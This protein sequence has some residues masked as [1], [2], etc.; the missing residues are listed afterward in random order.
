MEIIKF[1]LDVAIVAIFL[2]VNLSA[3]LYYASGK[4]T[5]REYAVGDKKFSTSTL[6]ATI[7]ATCIG[8]GF[9]SG[10]ITE[11]YKQG[12]Y[13]IIPAM[14]EPLALIIVGYFLIPR[15]SEF[16][17]CLSVADA[18]G[19]L[20]GRYVR[21]M[22]AMAGIFLCIG[23]VALQFKVGASILGIFFGISSFYALLLCAVIVT[24]YSAFGGI[25]AV[26]FTDVIQFFT[27][28][29]VIPVI[30]L[31]IWGTLNDPNVLFETLGRNP[32]FD[33]EQ[34]FDF[35]NSR[36]T[37]TIF[38]LMF[39]L[40][41][42]FQPVFFQRVIMARNTLQAKKAFVIG[43]FICLAILFI[44]SWV[45]I[46]LLSSNSNLDPNNLL[47]HIISTYSY[48][49]LKGLTA[50]GVM[51]VI[52]SSADSYINSA[53]VL[54]TNDILKAFRLNILGSISELLIASAFSFFVGAVGCILAFKSG[55][56]LGLLL[57]TFS[58]YTP[59][60]SA[61]LLLTI[62]GFRSS[63]RSVLTGIFAGCASVLICIYYEVADNIIPIASMMV[64]IAFLI[65]THYLFKQKGG[66]VGIKEQDA[67]GCMRYERGR[68]WRNIIKSIKEFSFI[69]FCRNNSPKH[70]YVYIFFGLF[71]IV[72]VFST[73]YS[74]PKGIQQ[75]NNQLIEFIYD[76][77]LFYSTIFLTYPIWPPILK[78]ERFVVIA[79][80][81]G[82][83]YI[84]LFSPI[85]L[86]IASNFGQFQSMVLMVNIIVIAMLV[87]WQIV[88]P[89]MFLSIFS[90]VKF[91]KWFVGIDN[92]LLNFGTLQFK[93]M[94]LLLM[95]SSVLI[96]F[97]RPQQQNQEISE[98]ITKHLRND[99][100]K[101]QL[102]LLRLSQYR[103]EFIDRLD[104]QC[105]GALRSIYQQVSVLDKDL[106]NEDDDNFEA[107][108]QEFMQIVGRVKAG[109]EYLD[110]VILQVKDLVKIH[111]S[112]VNLVEF[113][114]YIIDEYKRVNGYKDL[115]ISKKF[116]TTL[117]EIE[118]DPRLIESVVV[119][120]LN[121]GII[122][123]SSDTILMIFE[124]TILEYDNASNPLKIMREGIAISII[125]PHVTVE[126]EEIN[127][128]MN[129]TFN[130]VNEI[131]FAEVHRIIAA[132]YGKFSVCLDDFNRIV[133]NIT[134]PMQ[135]KDIRPKKMNLPDEQLSEIEEI[136]MLVTRRN[137]QKIYDIAVELFKSGMDLASISRI[138]KLTLSELDR[139]EL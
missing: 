111:S 36:F 92:I 72:S 58:F 85:L 79:W 23:I 123:S 30:S 115:Q 15:M 39:F 91:Y 55:T 21:M 44:I 102:E 103:Q 87:R 57:F 125:V 97:L 43:G 7:I 49:G 28:G 117:K 19:N 2:I 84:L 112:N 127:K 139:L 120:C 4:G 86:I 61:P 8:G 9:F 130:S 83:P 88:V 126:P 26:T 70:D 11:S 56:V 89:L 52:M 93:I 122:H 37:N 73:M 38:L 10:A 65:G 69:N 108:K 47:P 100:K 118:I 113:V 14:G 27:F 75:E 90:A 136:D 114:D 31:V 107:K 94:Y 82:V 81:I 138:T 18:L 5:L 60:V 132:H 68:K 32:L 42:D 105:V 53:A 24:I 119:T 29:T 110:N 74:I 98:I 137:Q 133:Y 129:P 25:K 48:P 40:I 80:N 96:A 45:G 22:T 78:S 41:P 124:S 6:A 128:I 106:Q 95:V 63:S 64:N 135:L 62:F 66:W 51:A 16:L 99:N 71:C 13:F 50:I 67:L 35:S 17:G 20:Y 76:T 3:G 1:D 33:Y 59:I 134:L 116:N 131:N 121:H 101:K 54:F 12:L 104:Q 34:V 77:V 109:M 46:L